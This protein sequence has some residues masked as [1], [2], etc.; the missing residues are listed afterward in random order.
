VR[1]HRFFSLEEANQAI[2]GLRNESTSDH[3]ANARKPRHAVRLS[4]TGRT[5]SLPATRY[6]FS[7][8]KKVRV[9]IDY[10]IVERHYYSRAALTGAAGSGSA[11]TAETIEFCIAA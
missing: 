3:F 6:Q 8:W 7:E 10:H 1:K 11:P 4:W 2:A 5:A 9:N